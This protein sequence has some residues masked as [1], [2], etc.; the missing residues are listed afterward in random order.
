MQEVEMRMLTLEQAKTQ[1]QRI[2]QTED[3]S[4]A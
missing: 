2:F 1:T 4:L 3:L